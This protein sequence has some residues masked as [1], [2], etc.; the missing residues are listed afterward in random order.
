MILE[1]LR[2]FFE[3]PTWKMKLVSVG[4]VP[5]RIG[6]SADHVSAELFD[7]VDKNLIN[8]KCSL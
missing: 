8:G 3:N 5:D 2:Y 4:I 6:F 7:V 1:T